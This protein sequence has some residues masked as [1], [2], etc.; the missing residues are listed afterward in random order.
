MIRTYVLRNF[1][2]RKVRTILMILALV[3]GVGTLATLNATVDSY[4][5]YYAG[6]VSGEVGDF[7]LVITLP[8]TAA[9]RMLKPSE[10]QPIVE[11][12][13]G[14][15]SVA[16]RIHSVVSVK[17]GTK[18][19]DKPFVALDPE[20]DEFGR[21][22][23]TEGEY[24]LGVGDD[25]LPGAIVLQESADVLD[26]EVGDPIEILYA[27]PLSRMKGQL[28]DES[29]SRQSTRATWIVRGIATQRGTTG[30]E[31]NEGVIV[32][33]QS[34]RQRFGLG[35]SAERLVVDFDRGVYDSSD[36]QRSAFTARD[37][38]YGVRAALGD[39]YD[40]IMPRPRAVVD[41]AQQFIMFQSLVAMYGLLSMGVV[42]LL[43]RT[44]IMTNVQ[45]QTRDMAVM[46][47][48][49]A[50]QR[51]LFN[52]VAAEVVVIGAIGVG[53]G[54]VVGQAINNYVIV[55]FIEQ[56]SVSTGA[57]TPLISVSAIVMSVVITGVVLAVSAL[58]PAR[59]AAN[60]KVTHA[61]NPGVA[62]GIGLDELA[63]MRERR[64]DV[65][66]TGIGLVVLIFPALIFFAFPLAFDFGVLWVMAGLI[67][68]SILAL[69]VGTALVF[70]LVILP[71]E[72]LNLFIIDRFAPRAG[73]FVRRT[74]LRGK[75]RNTLISL[76]IVVSATL[77]TFLATT[78]ALEVANI[79]TDRRLNY[80]APFRI[81]PPVPLSDEGSFRPE[82][83]TE[84]VFEYELLDEVRADPG[85]GSTVAL[86]KSYRTTAEDGVGLRDAQLWAVGVD[87]D[88]RDV[89][90]PEA[91]TMV[92]GDSSA[93][94]RIVEEPGTVVIGA[95]LATHLDR[96]V[97]DT[98]ILKGEGR[99]HTEE[100][101]V[102]GVANRVG[103]VGSFSAKQTEIWMG[104]N[105]AVMGFDTYRQL[106]TDPTTGPP[107][108]NEKIV[109]RLLATP[110]AGVDEAELTTA[111]RLAYATK[112]SLF[113]NST[114]E[115]IQTIKEESRTGQLF[116]I[117]LTA[118]TSVL[119]I[120]GVF[121]V[122]YVSVYGRR[123]EIGML[124]AIG[125]PG[126]HLTKVFVGEAMVM[127]LS[128][129]LTGVVAGVVLAYALR[130]SQSFQAEMPTNFAFDPVV[131]PAMLVFMILAAFISA[132]VATHSYRRRRAIDILRTV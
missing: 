50:P 89:L 58:A 65:R 35:Q 59:K 96:G 9:N 70:F 115:V 112:H 67:M 92:E 52:T 24:D 46:R 34:A 120:F 128:A 107:D 47:I 2:R 109:R 30:Q 31:S 83:A 66:I 103:G 79:E 93:L 1:G 43:I 16:P 73:Y 45:E 38:A 129:T 116:L 80:G 5:R 130:L 26:I 101:E 29:G 54:I 61:I 62:E 104:Q 90:Y 99:D 87:G 126:R 119:A 21:I 13:P 51:H 48:L 14:V 18:E 98:L 121:A 15:E 28:P 108:P 17:A 53:I 11:S 75:E 72:R 86:T 40:Y 100:V 49:G 36:P 20:I 94:A 39:G 71:M 23:V 127:T 106:T 12:V 57:E 19:G 77:P 95:A 88:V 124:K 105:T 55:P 64:T 44:L 97:G 60:T 68:G 78:L 132:V 56:N 117:V 111:L 82:V 102:V 125:S 3:V 27:P 4:R 10:L 69:I 7:D 42:G 25:G 84:G 91:L 76:M 8:D 113:I 122:I 114:A 37:I 22:D 81:T 118:L 41:G 33:L 85:F 74:V 6:A 63:K 123:A 32:S 131:V 110:A